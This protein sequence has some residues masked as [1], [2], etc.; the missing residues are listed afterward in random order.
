MKPSPNDIMQF[1]KFRLI[2]LFFKTCFCFPFLQPFFANSTP[3]GKY[4]FDQ[5][6]SKM[7]FHVNNFGVFKVDGKFKKFSGTIIFDP[8][9]E[10]SQAEA[11]AEI[12]S[13]D[14]DNPSRDKHLQSSDFFDQEKFFKMT[15]K[16]KKI[17]GNIESFKLIGDLTIKEITKEVI[18]YVENKE[19]I[20]DKEEFYFTAQTTI[21]RNDFNIKYGSTISNKVTIELKIHAINSN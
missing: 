1:V 18:L 21:N 5:S 16:S 8:K 15:F 17:E 7:E 11:S 9:F 19:N 4:S 2:L 3:I 13:I 12:S 20:K 6:K 10:Q 14:T